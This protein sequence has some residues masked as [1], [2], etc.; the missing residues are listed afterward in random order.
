M[1]TKMVQLIGMTSLA[2]LACAGTAAKAQAQSDDNTIIVTGERVSRA[3]RDTASSVDVT[4]GR[5]LEDIAGVDSVKEILSL[6][7][8]VLTTGSAN[9]GPTIRGQNTTG[10]LSAVDAFFGGSRP[11]T[12]ILVDGR[13]LSYNEF[14]YN[15]TGAW[16]ISQVEVFLGPQTTSQG[17]NSIAGIINV[18]TNDPSGELEGAVRGIAGNYGLR[19]A[20][21]MLNLPIVQDQLALRVSG[22][23]NRQR[24]YLDLPTTPI[25][26]DP[27]RSRYTNLRAKL[28]AEPEAM[29]GFRALLTYSFAD[30][31]RTQS[32][33]VVPPAPG[34]K[35][36]IYPP[37]EATSFGSKTH[38]GIA[39]LSYQ[40]GD[41]LTLSNRFIY[42]D[43]TIR[44]YAPPG[45]GAAL[46]KRDE[47]SNETLLTYGRAGDALSGVMGVY[48]Q[49]TSQDESTD[50]AGFGLGDG[51]FDDKTK[52]FGVFGEL[53]VS[54]AS[55]LF[56]TAGVRYQRDSQDRRGGFPVLP[57]IIYDEKFDAVLPKF[58]VA[59]DVNDDLRVGVEA[60]RG[61]NPGG[62]SFSFLTAQ[63]DTF[64]DERLWN[65]EFYWRADLLG[66]ALQING[67]IFYTDFEDTQRPVNRVIP[68][69]GIVTDLAQAEDARSYG[70]EV[71]LRYRVHRTL[72]FDLGV[73]LLSTKLKRVTGQP[74]LEG[75][76]FQRAPGATATLG[77][78]WE[79][80]K[81][82]TLSAQGRYVDSYYSDD[83]N[84]KAFAIESY[85]LANAQLAY[86]YRGARLFG[87]V[88]NVFD[89]YHLLQDFG[90]NTATATDPRRY[91]VGVE[92]RF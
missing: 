84:R 14:I 66:S 61:Y 20:S 8:N 12:T 45:L 76:E 64:E 85:F 27:E 28:L 26:V 3:V 43:V 41:K 69:L 1:R 65:Y 42:S 86:E 32:E 49:K 18:R 71:Q 68:G 90:F 37:F 47:L 53:T 52:A 81:N 24:S 74:D 46:I 31:L 92:F 50:F 30:S 77:V 83:A 54:P 62:L 60:R 25:G 80:I 36:R 51:F 33:L 39:D 22:D 13:P 21:A 88:T 5:E 70:A 75:K 67:N 23:H 16:D 89:E 44:R 57:T 11:R 15:D 6:S 10:I 29:P 48:F 91:G 38:T 9:D 17:V 73:G 19:Q 2:A 7:P 72:S 4:T 79:P 56:L 87:Y 40:L 59:Y 58:G 55:R 82:L 35:D 63:I 78:Q 34:S